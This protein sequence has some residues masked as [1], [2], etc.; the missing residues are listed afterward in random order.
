MKRKPYKFDLKKPVYTPP[1]LKMIRIQG[2]LTPIQVT[3]F[4][5]VHCGTGRVYRES[6]DRAPVYV[7]GKCGKSFYFDHDPAMDVE[8]F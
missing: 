6:K 4:H 5:C 7:C 8:P 1:K 2:I 3:P